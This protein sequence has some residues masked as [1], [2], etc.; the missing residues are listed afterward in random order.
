MAKN[1]VDEVFPS[2]VKNLSHLM[3]AILT[4][5]VSSKVGKLRTEEFCGAK[6][7]IRVREDTNASWCQ[8]KGQ[9][10]HAPEAIEQV[11]KQGA[12]WK[13]F[14]E[15]IRV[16]KLDYHEH[17]AEH[18][19]NLKKIKKEHWISEW[20]YKTSASPTTNLLLVTSPIGSWIILK[21]KHTLK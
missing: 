17:V 20:I 8:R 12:L 3:N 6:L 10:T 7:I 2:E 9:I 19:K 4:E 13:E 11:F 15:D 1:Y 18:D 14:I 21:K 16:M 5:A